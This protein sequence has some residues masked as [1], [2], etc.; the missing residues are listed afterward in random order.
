MNALK[1][2][3]KLESA[4]GIIL[5]AATVLAMIIANSPLDHVYGLLLEAPME[6]RIGPLYIAKPLHM[7]SHWS[8]PAWDPQDSHQLGPWSWRQLDARADGHIRHP[9]QPVSS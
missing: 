6:I 4:A 8:E 2:F 5:V 3:V 9:C 7:S 1:D